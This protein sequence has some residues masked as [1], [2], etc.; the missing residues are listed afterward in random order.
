MSE[1]DSIS[2]LMLP[3]LVVGLT[4]SDPVLVHPFDEI[5]T[6]ELLE[7]E[8]LN[9]GS[10]VRRN[11]SAVGVAIGRVWRWGTIVLAAQIAV[12]TVGTVTKC[13]LVQKI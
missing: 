3:E 11:D 9:A 13:L 1:Y 12:L 6:T 7:G 5:V 10:L 8:L 2:R 4:L